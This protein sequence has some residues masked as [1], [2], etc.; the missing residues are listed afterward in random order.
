MISSFLKYRTEPGVRLWRGYTLQEFANQCF[1]NKLDCAKG[2]QLPI[3]YGSKTQI[4]HAVGAA[5]SFKMYGEKYTITYFGDGCTSE[6]DSHAALDF[7]AVMEVPVIFCHNNGDG[8]VVQ[9]QAYGI[10]SIRMGGNDVL[11]SEWKENDEKKHKRLIHFISI[12]EGKFQNAIKK[13]TK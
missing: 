7:A 12:T 4:P 2:R 10:H 8:A 5:Y 1:G 3:H 11:K 9:G 13:T 6:G